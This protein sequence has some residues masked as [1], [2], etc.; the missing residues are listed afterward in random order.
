MTDDARCPFPY[1]WPGG[2]ETCEDTGDPTGGGS[3]SRTFARAAAGSQ[4]TAT[5]SVRAVALSSR[6]PVSTVGGRCRPTRCS[7]PDV[8]SRAPDQRAGVARG[9][10]PAPGQRAV[11]RPHRLH[12]LRRA[13]RPGAG[14]RAAE[15]LLRHRPPGDRPVRRGGREVHRRRGHGAVRRAGGHRDR[16]GALRPGRP[17][18]ATGAGPLRRPAAPQLR[19][20]VGVATGEALVDVAAARDGGQAIVAGDVV[21]TASRL[22]SLA[23]AGGVLVCGTTYAARPRSSISYAAQPP[24][25]LRGRST[26]TEV[27]LAVARC[28]ATTRPARPARPPWSTA[29]TSSACWSTRCTGRCA[30]GTPQLVTVLGPAGIGKSRL[31][32]GAVPARR[33][34]APTTRS[35]GAS[36]GARRSARTSPTPRWPTS[37]RP[38][39]AC[40]TPTP[41]TARARAARRARSGDLVDPLERPGCPTPLRPLVG[42]PG[43]QARRRR[44]RV[45]LAALPARAGRAPARP[46]WSSRTCTGPT[47]RCSRFVERLGA[48]GPRRAA[49][50]GLHRPAGAA[51]PGPELDRHDH[52]LGHDHAAAD[53]RRR[54]SPPSTRSCSAQATFPPA[55]RPRWSSSPTATRS[56]P[57]STPGCW[58]SRARCA[59]SDAL[60]LDSSCRM[61]HSVHAV[62]ANRVDLLDPTDRAVLQAAAVVGVQ[63]WPGA[64]AAALG[65]PVE[66]V[67]RSLRRLEQRDLVHEQAASTMAGQTE[68][69]FRPRPGPRRLLPAAA[70]DRAGGAAR[71]H[72][73][74]ARHASPP[75]G[76]PTWPRCSPTTAGRPTRSPARSGW[77]SAA[78]AAPARDAL[79]RAARRAYALHALDV[80]RRATPVGRS[81]WRRRA[82]TRGGWVELLG[83]EIAFYRDGNAF[84]AGGA[85][86]QARTRWPSGSP[87]PATD[88]GA[89]RAWTL[90][91]Q[92]AWLRADRVE[93]AALPGPGG[94]ALRRAAGQP[95]EGRRV[96]WSWAGCTCSTTEP[97][98]GR[99]G[100]ATRR[101]RSPSGSA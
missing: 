84:L 53:A 26:P 55:A 65:R 18:A 22:Q 16:R 79:H 38:R 64:V 9:D 72:R 48:A 31:R 40:W 4:T 47:R 56:T 3:T 14:P 76:T 51:G 8:A 96:R 92:A 101:R 62:I 67:E 91:G 12:A 39:P 50:G 93:R 80:R 88:A 99:R 82:P 81:P 35:R 24:V 43:S 71:A 98:P 70:P 11:R 25:T 13:G 90:L 60:T 20:R 10:R 27:W 1:T 68:Y 5:G 17:G 7:A 61:P 52:R 46:C 77:T 32:A 94:R 59:S 89:A 49:A 29:T 19:F 66:S 44:D 37:S 95:G 100:G 73:R 69:R 57:R 54:A 42:L 78:Y 45:G 6:S 33:A 63:F 74:L 21:N 23:P 83:T 28:A 86:E 34:A 36:G 97:R 75:T 41:P 30:S 85:P 87:R 15:R 58:S 2:C